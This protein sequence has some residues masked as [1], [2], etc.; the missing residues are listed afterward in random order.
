MWVVEVVPS[1]LLLL[2]GIVLLR[3]QNS[4]WTT[5]V[6]ELRKLEGTIQVLNGQLKEAED[7]IAML[8]LQNANGIQP[9][10]VVSV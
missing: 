1:V 2:L 3:T 4:L 7:E 9:S 10:Q 5:C 6:K 8:R